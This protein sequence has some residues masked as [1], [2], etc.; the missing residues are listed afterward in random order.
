MGRTSGHVRRCFLVT[1]FHSNHR[2]TQY[3]QLRYTPA[4]IVTGFKANIEHRPI[5]SKEAEEYLFD[6]ASN[7]R[8]NGVGGGHDPYGVVGAQGGGWK[9]NGL[10]R[11]GY[12]HRTHEPWV[13]AVR[14]LLPTAHQRLS[15]S[16]ER[17]STPP[18][19]IQQRIPWHQHIGVQA[20]RYRRCGS[21]LNPCDEPSIPP[22]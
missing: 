13:W 22:F 15:L 5:N 4:L 8:R 1:I 12:M 14:T 16:A 3:S 21:L 6:S 7:G 11:W 18:P 10:L 2:Q 19:V 9:R 20:A 17:G